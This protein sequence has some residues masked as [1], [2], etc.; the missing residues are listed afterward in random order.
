VDK[1]LAQYQAKKEEH[2]ALLRIPATEL[3]RQDIQALLAQIDLVYEQEEKERQEAAVQA[4]S[5]RPKKK[6]KKRKPA[7][8]P[9]DREK[10]KDQKSKG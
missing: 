7:D 3:W 5:S 9:R 6:Q 4:K 10:D 2:D 8:K 1:L